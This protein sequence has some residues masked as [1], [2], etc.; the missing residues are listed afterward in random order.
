MDEVWLDETLA[1]ADVDED[2]IRSI[3]RDLLPSDDMWKNTD[4]AQPRVLTGKPW[5]GYVGVAALTSGTE[6]LL[7]QV[8]LKFEFITAG[9]AQFTFAR[10]QARLDPISE[11]EPI[12]TVYDLY[13]LR[14]EDGDQKTVSVSVGPS[15]RLGAAKLPLAE[16]NSDLT[17][18]RVQPS[19]VG[20]TGEDERLPYWDVRPSRHP[21]LGARYFWLLIAQPRGCT[22]VRLRARVDA[23]LQTRWGPI[24][25]FPQRRVWS[26]RPFVEIR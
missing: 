15:L 9:A 5:W 22:G 18:G 26:D 1:M 10:C 8:R 19:V 17:F 24:A 4:E 11:N 14:I 25:F 7:W 6:A 21:I 12:P 20:Y 2:G 16:V 13:P 3:S 23:Q